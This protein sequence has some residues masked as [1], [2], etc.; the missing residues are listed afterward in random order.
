MKR[1]FLL[2][3]LALAVALPACRSPEAAARPLVLELSPAHGAGLGADGRAA[4]EQL[5]TASAGLAVRV[6]VARDAASAVEAFAGNAADA[7]LLSLFEYMLA[8]H[9]YRVEARLQLLRGQNQ[10]NYVGEIVIRDDGTVQT[11]K[12][13]QGRPLAFV[14]EYSVSGFLLPARRLK[15]E[16]VRPV[17]RFAGSHPAAIQALKDKQVDAAAVFHGAIAAEPGLKVLANT[18]TVP[19]EPLFVRRGLAPDRAAA[20]VKAVAALPTT[21]EGRALLLRLGNITGLSPVTD[22]GYDDVAKDI[23]EI[24]LGVEDLVPGGRALAVRN[25]VQILAD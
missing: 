11:L 20:L 8:R 23:A 22:K 14:D 25:R 19:N 12:D 16:G 17:T 10:A 5:L 15:D 4:L 6:N 24:G 2:R 3:S 9:E 18:G 1:A 13:L 7:G 21:D